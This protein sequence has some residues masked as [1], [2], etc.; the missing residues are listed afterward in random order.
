MVLRVVY[1]S[2]PCTSGGYMPPY[3]VPQGVHLP[4]CV[5]GVVTGVYLPGCVR[6]CIP[7]LYLPGCVRRCI[8]GLCLPGCVS[9]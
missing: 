6:W 9:V 4:G 7:G 5:Q 8:P 1:A 2:L 3:R